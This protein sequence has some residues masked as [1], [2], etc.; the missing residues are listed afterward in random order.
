[1]S[2]ILDALRKSERERRAGQ[3]PGL[4]SVVTET[5]VR[6]SR[7]LYLLIGLLLSLNLGGLALWW[8]QRG[9]EEQP[10]PAATAGGP[11]SAPVTTGVETPA[12]SADRNLNPPIVNPGQPVSTA[13]ATLPAT[14]DPAAAAAPVPV[15]PSTTAAAAP[16]LAPAT[17]VAPPA[18]S[19]APQAPTGTPF[20]PP[21]AVAPSP[22]PAA[23]P[24]PRQNLRGS[25]MSAIA[26]PALAPPRLPRSRALDEGFEEIDRELE[27]EGENLADARDVAADVEAPRARPGVQPGTPDYRELPPE[28][29][30]RIPPFRITMFAYSKNP[31]ER[32][33]I[34]DMKKYRT[35]DRLP[36]GIL[37]LAIQA[38]NLLLELDGQKFLVPRF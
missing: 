33:V 4:P 13:A 27:R 9:A 22:A 8:V 2:Y 20:S 24:P 28:L 10:K 19:P 34:I 11:V 29:Q 36:G 23:A 37:L 31:A 30:A 7:W 15:A 32:F 14:S 6:Q 16:T 5:P 12:A 18:P 1:M 3:V 35:G 38:E 21:V 25:R 26:E 17:A